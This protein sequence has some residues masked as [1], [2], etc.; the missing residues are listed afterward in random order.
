MA[1]NAGAELI[2]KEFLIHYG[3]AR[4]LNS[5]DMQKH[6]ESG[7]KK[8]VS[9]RVNYREYDY[10]YA[11]GHG[12]TGWY[13]PTQNAEGHTLTM[14]DSFAW[15]AHCGRGPLY[16]DPGS[17]SDTPGRSEWIKTY[18]ERIGT[19]A[20]DKIG[21]DVFK[22]DKILW[23][24]SRVFLIP[25]HA[26]SGIHPVNTHC[27]TGVPGLFAAGNCCGTMSSGASYAG[28]GFGLNHA[29]VTGARAGIGAAD[30]ASSCKEVK[31]DKD[32]VLNIKQ[33]V[34]NPLE[35]MGGF[36]PRWLTQTLHGIIVPYY[37]L[38]V[39]HEER[40]QAS[41]T[42]IKNLKQHIVPKLMAKDAHELRLVHETKS[43]V[44]MAEMILKSSLFRT[45]SRGCHF[46][47]DYPE[48]NDSTWLAW[49]KL[50]DKQ[51]EI[52]L[53]KEPVPQKWW[54]KA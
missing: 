23:P 3:M 2:S 9:E 44:L 6:D 38:G 20:A 27:A 21:M 29:M 35:R 1:Y 15:E 48:R 19:Y 25:P 34:C 40:L 37:V 4:T 13:S 41:I 42:L 33:N 54:P 45:E 7:R 36:S 28:M 14:G 17:Y 52:K 31:P 22:S 32:I 43:M 16:H 51:G 26:G 10:P 53:S 5:A 50:K 47:E 18:L 46:R 8:D 12:Y 49:V 39:K 30:Y 11:L 24:S